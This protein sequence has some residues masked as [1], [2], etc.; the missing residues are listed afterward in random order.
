M[1]QIPS[2][3]SL[4]PF[5]PGGLGAAQPSVTQLL[6]Q[7]IIEPP[8]G[9]RAEGGEA[10]K[11][12]GISR[13]ARTPESRSKAKEQS[14]GRTGALDVQVRSIPAGVVLDGCASYSP[15][16]KGLSAL[17][18]RR[19]STFLQFPYFLVERVPATR[20]VGRDHSCDNRSVFS[21]QVTGRRSDPCV[22]S[23]L[24]SGLNR[25]APAADP[26]RGAGPALDL[27]D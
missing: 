24:T 11:C 19:L 3:G 7:Q 8:N 21:A 13:A 15:A 5:G 20:F 14:E 12:L 27:A 16:R 22:I 17:F 26:A 2:P 4:N 23:P 6:S 9:D 1:R 18:R 10:H 25:Y